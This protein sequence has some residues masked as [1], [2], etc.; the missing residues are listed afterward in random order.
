MNITVGWWRTR[1][2]RKARVLCTDA[3]DDFPCIGYVLHLGN[4]MARATQWSKDG[5]TLEDI[6]TPEDLIEPW[7]DRPV[8]DW[9]KMPAWA[10]KVWWSPA[11]KMWVWTYA[12]NNVTQS[13]IPKA[14]SPPP[15]TG[16]PEDSLVERP[17]EVAK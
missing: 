7:I 3:E 1:D 13:P 12:H 4:E 16:K 10:E 2:G 11:W 9:S 5:R 15:W 14:F 17:K 8:I 6:Q